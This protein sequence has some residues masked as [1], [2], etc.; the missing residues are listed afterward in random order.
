MKLLQILCAVYLGIIGSSVLLFIF[1]EK[2][3]FAYVQLLEHRQVLID[4]I[5][6][7]QAK[8]QNLGNQ[9]QQLRSDPRYLQILARELGYYATEESV[10]R[11]QGFPDP[12][13][14]YELGRIIKFNKTYPVKNDYLRFIGFI[15]SLVMLI[16][17]ILTDKRKPDD[18]QTQLNGLSLK[19]N[20]KF[21]KA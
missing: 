11:L 4:N 8:N 6:D 20:R 9:L 17:F 7:L 3:Y 21:R 13:S 15:F 5:E 18:N 10:L 2:G 16:I 14:F 12:G 1:G 19:H